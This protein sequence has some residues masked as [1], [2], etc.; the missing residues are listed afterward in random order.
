MQA[1]VYEGYFENGRFRVSG[2]TIKI[3]E[4]RRVLVTVLDEQ[5][6]QDITMAEHLAAMDDFINQIKIS[7][8]KVP[9]FEKIKFREVE[10]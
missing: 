1:Q 3:P 9:E 6:K 5:P 8:E 7:N 2:Q 4:H 10:I